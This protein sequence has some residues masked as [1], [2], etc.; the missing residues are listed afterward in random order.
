MCF[1]VMDL[2][3]GPKLYWFGAQSGWGWATAATVRICGSTLRGVDLVS[4]H[5]TFSDARIIYHAL[6]KSGLDQE[7]VRHHESL[8]S[9]VLEE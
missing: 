6:P 3:L 7:D 8:K 4:L 5:L 2:V 1:R 9:M